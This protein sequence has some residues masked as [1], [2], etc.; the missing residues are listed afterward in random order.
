[1]K[2]RQIQSPDNETTRR[3]LDA[4]TQVFA[5]VGFAGARVDSIAERAGI[6]KAALYYHIGGKEELYAEVLRNLVGDAPEQGIKMIQ[7]T[8]S[9]EDKLRLY[10]R[11]LAQFIESRPSIAPI[12][13]REM[14]SGGQH[15]SEFLIQTMLRIITTLAGILAEGEQQGIFAP[16]IPMALH[17]MTMGS[18]IFFKIRELIL[19]QRTDVPELVKMIWE[20]NLSGNVV[21]EIEKLILKSVKKTDLEGEITEEVA[22]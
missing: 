15:L 18:L 5:E 1:M 6:N 12:M 4:A 2:H 14:A 22:R 21:E 10:I 9:P 19:A 3:I 7:A 20:K 13:L 11:N 17:F 16:T 8:A